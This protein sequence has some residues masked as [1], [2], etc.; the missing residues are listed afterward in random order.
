LKHRAN[1]LEDLARSLRA[2]GW[3]MVFI[4]QN[5]NDVGDVLQVNFGVAVFMGLGPLAQKA[6]E[7]CAAVVKGFPG[8]FR[9]E[10]LVLGAEHAH[11]HARGEFGLHRHA[12]RKP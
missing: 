10:E 5:P 2:R 9:A 11:A 12:L 7:W 6:R 4:S 1:L 8:A 3:R